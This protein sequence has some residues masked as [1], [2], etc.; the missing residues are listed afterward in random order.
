MDTDEALAEGEAILEAGVED[1]VPYVREP[2][3]RVLND[4]MME[5]IRAHAKHGVQVLPDGIAPDRYTAELENVARKTTDDRARAGRL[6]WVD[7]AREEW[8]E[9]L[10]AETPEHRREEAVQLTQVLVSW[11]E[12]M[13][14][15]DE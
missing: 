5:Q 3:V 14:K 7:V 8:Y 2:T 15:R 10:N 1:G 13:D 11:I 12:D 4:V 9:L 6:T